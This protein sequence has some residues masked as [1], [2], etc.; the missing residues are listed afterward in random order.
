MYTLKI[1][2]LYEYYQT[3]EPQRERVIDLITFKQT[4]MYQKS[5]WS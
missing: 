4:S 5:A 2:T 1:G 3:Q